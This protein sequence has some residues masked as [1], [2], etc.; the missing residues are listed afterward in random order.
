MAEP[1]QEPRQAL[2]VGVTTFEHGL[3]NLP[4][5]P[6]RRLAD[7]I[8]SH[9][10]TV[11]HA[12]CPS[13]KEL[14]ELLS[15]VPGERFDVVHLL[16]HGQVSRSKRLLIAGSDARRPATESHQWV[17]V[18]NTVSE[19][20]DTPG[21]PVL[22]LLDV[23][24]AG[25]AAEI[26]VDP[27][28]A[29][30]TDNDRKVY[31]LAATAPRELAFDARFTRAVTAVLDRIT[32]GDSLGA[33]RSV[34]HISLSLVRTAIADELQRLCG[35]GPQQRLVSSRHSW[36]DLTHP[37]FRNR[38]Y[39]STAID[40]DRPRDPAL[41][42]TVD[43]L[44]GERHFASRARGGD[45]SRD[46][47]WCH[48]TGRLAELR[49]LCRWL[50]DSEQDEWLRVVTGS[51][52]MGKS[53]L[54]GVLVCLTHNE[55][56]AYSAVVE[57]RI[58]D[59]AAKPN[60]RE[61]DEMAAV[62]ARNREVAELVASIA[63]QLGFE[64][65]TNAADLI[66]KLRS[67]P[68][69][70]VVIVDALDEAM[71]PS[72]V[73]LRLLV[74]L[75]T[76][77]VCRLLVGTRKQ[78]RFDDLFSIA[79]DGRIDLD[80]F[81]PDQLRAH[82][83]AYVVDLLREHARRWPSKIA[84]AFA[85][86]TAKTVTPIGAGAVE[87]GP[88]LL[89]QLH[90]HRVTRGMAPETTATAEALG[91][92]APQSV[93]DAFR[94]ELDSEGTDPWLGPMLVAFAHARGTGMPISLARAIAR[95]LNPGLPE[96]TNQQLA[97]LMSEQARF[98][99]RSDIDSSDHSALY[100]LFHQSLQEY[101]TAYP[102][103]AVHGSTSERSGPG[104]DGLVFE[105][106]LDT[107]G[108]IPGLSGDW[109]NRAVPYLRRHLGQHGIA[110]GR[111]DELVDDLGFL[112]HAEHDELMRDLRLAKSKD[113]RLAAAIYRSSHDFHRTA[114]PEDRLRLLALDA[115]RFGA[116][117]LHDTTATI[118]GAV[119]WSTGTR[120]DVRM[121]DV[122]EGHV[123][124]VTSVAC[125]SVNDRPVAVTGGADA[126]VRI[127]DL[128]T[129]TPVGEPLTGHTQPIASIACTVLDGRPIA[130]T[131]GADTM[132][133]GGGTAVRIWDLITRT[134]LGQPLDDQ[135]GRV[136][137]LACADLD[138]R[139]VVVIARG[140][141]PNVQV[142]DLATRAAVGE[143]LP[144]P[145]TLWGGAA[146][147]TELGGR[148]VA[149]IAT[150]E[151]QTWRVWDLASRTLVGEPLAET[152]PWQGAIAF[153]EMNGHLIAGSAEGLGGTL[154]VWGL[155]T[156]KQAGELL[157]GHTRTVR[158]VTFT[159]F[160]ELPVMITGSDDT[161]VRVWNL[162][163]ETQVAKPLR[164]HTSQL[165]ALALT[166]VG[167]RPVV[168]TGGDDRDVRVWDL[169]TGAAVGEPLSGH[170]HPVRSMACTVLNGGQVVVTAGADH[171][172]R[173]WDLSTGGMIGTLPGDTG[174]VLAIACTMLNARPVTVIVGVEMVLV[175]DL[176]AGLPIRELPRSPSERISSVACTT[177]RGRPVA[178]IGGDTGVQ[179]WDLGTG[180]PI[181]E[182]HTRA[183]E[184]VSAIDCSSLRGRPIAVAG[185][186]MTVRVWD[187]A[188]GE[189]L[190]VHDFPAPVRAAV[191]APQTL[192]VGYGMDVAALHCPGLDSER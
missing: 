72:D 185:G 104:V 178:V 97:E 45:P 191:C 74:P 164:G 148:P 15:R 182:M 135:S 82:V 107:F 115:A 170:T 81:A 109:A 78:A 90:T 136:R 138:G 131:G 173:I 181:R 17:S 102:Y 79:A 105:A 122:L 33:D 19:L 151:D 44:L 184:K 21:D 147:F 141:E 110:A 169:A 28:D 9:D 58:A 168:V 94:Q 118:T 1:G 56:R 143:A 35:N 150:L 55:L 52:G 129:G 167:G 34:E 92:W 12:D 108:Y 137:A 139:A 67:S 41:G 187:L 140:S 25:A 18:H 76:A 114:R 96:R 124:P 60:P 146:G 130:V 128:I 186:E 31:V 145:A 39:T 161:T 172:P 22:V 2:V 43:P 8:R 121:L 188:T 66:T 142:W 95:G 183:A 38:N 75:A 11:V 54:L 64:N 73:L 68:P 14:S 16:S 98:Y 91:N 111:F 99:L 84:T 113:A 103:V 63:R 70:V 162:D 120:A 32:Q 155:T 175:W 132:I 144:Q 127:W 26:D 29:D 152:Y 69:R 123:G 24:Y 192:V 5:E 174:S 37:L 65:V 86:A 51:P 159:E 3:T 83:A 112:A 49:A 7:A 88:M 190:V 61:P 177:L 77:E 87:V 71:D 180:D 133:R 62:H 106:L 125:A 134:Q 13:R 100:A 53:A 171:T 126:T 27:L 93:K 46:T 20:I 50:D 85:E 48:F 119:R 10:R 30:N 189:H 157:Y 47:A 149:I 101:L 6:A 158:A 80:D 40:P 163:A 165:R 117:T 156:G 42:D 166:E 160:D 23:C 116:T 179:V 176:T 57:S 89:A 4:D 153:T 154:R 59:P 36:D